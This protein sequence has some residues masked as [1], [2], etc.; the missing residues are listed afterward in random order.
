MRVFLLSPA[1]SSGKRAQ[2]LLRPAADFALARQLRTK[3]GA[4]LGDVYAFLS[5]LYFRGKIT[6][7]RAFAP[8]S[9]L[10]ITPDRGLLP[11]ET[12]VTAAALR[13]FGTI[14]IADDDARFSGPLLRD[15][16][17]IAADHPGAEVVLLGSIASNKYV[18]HLGAVF[19]DRLVFP[20][21]FVGRGDMSRGGLML[22]AA[23]E[24]RELT[25][26]R[27]LGATRHG[28]RP[29]KLAPVPGILRDAR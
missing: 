16:R 5:G 20:E 23:R 29:P 28:K 7:A 24:G 15:A 25:Y 6:Y 17:R 14:D 9:S 10:V 19:G 27:V 18:T 26:Q 8:E 2:I 11:P 13:R 3:R 21:D 12:F 4:P 1:S 22:R